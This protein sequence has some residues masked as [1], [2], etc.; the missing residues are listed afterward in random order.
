MRIVTRPAAVCAGLLIALLAATPALASGP[1]GGSG[2]GGSIG[3]GGGTGCSGVACYANVWQYI[4]L[5]GNAAGGGGG[6]GIP[7]QMPPPPCYMEPMFSGPELYALWKQ[8]SQFPGNPQFPF[9]KYLGLI[10]QYKASHAGYWWERVINLQVRGTCGLPLLGWVGN[11]QPPP[12]PQV[13]AIDLSIYA[14]DHM[15][16]PSPVLKLNPPGGRGYVSL[17]SYVWAR[18]PFNVGTVT[19]S[20]GNES[21]TVTA[22][23]GTLR[24]RAGQPGGATVYDSG[25][26]VN[27]STA[28]DPPQNAG[29]GTTPDC[30]VTFTAPSRD[31]S[32][33]G[34]IRW[35]VTSNYRGF[36]AITTATTAGVEVF[37]IQ[38]LNNN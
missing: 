23:A 38:S 37:E 33:T 13:P 20:L 24:L 36:P 34:S 26:T 10:K 4:R 14:Y 31:N 15:T 30:G 35:T 28:P 5:S 32:V 29:P 2:P 6:G 27:G 25:C 1:V 12:L 17:P 21:A 22:T 9:Q 3:G 16:L 8:G 7:I 19:A 18:L 11:G